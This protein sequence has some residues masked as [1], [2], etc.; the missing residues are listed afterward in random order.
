[1]EQRLYEAL[2][3]NPI[4]AAVR[5]DEGLAQC[6]R[7]DIQTVFV[8]YGDICNIPEIVHQIK[9]AGKIAIVHADLI[10]GLATKEISVDFL[11][12]STLADGIISTRANMIQRAREFNMIAILRVSFS[13]FP[14]ANP[15]IRHFV[16]LHAPMDLVLKTP[17][18]QP[19]CT[20][21][22]ISANRSIQKNQIRLPLPHGESKSHMWKRLLHRRPGFCGVPLPKT[23]PDIGYSEIR[24]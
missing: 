11:R 2:Q 15:G 24:P 1:M 5:D 19:F 10:S 20:A 3:R 18:V 23:R 8:L 7:T 13:L 9:D 16:L 17:L 12:H 4:I 14:S 22:R 6:L 21:A